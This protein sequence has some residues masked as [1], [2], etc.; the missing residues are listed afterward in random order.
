MLI[1]GKTIFNSITSLLTR[2]L[3]SFWL[4]YMVFSRVRLLCRTQPQLSEVSDYCLNMRMNK[5]KEI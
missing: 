2:P 3:L 5:K 4:T 1:L